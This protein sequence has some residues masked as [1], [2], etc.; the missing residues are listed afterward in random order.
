MNPEP[1]PSQTIGPFFHD[2]LLDGDRSEPVS[3]DH[4]DPVSD[5]LVEIWQA[6]RRRARPRVLSGFGSAVR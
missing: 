1:T 6:N 5:A 2:A 3:P 4:P